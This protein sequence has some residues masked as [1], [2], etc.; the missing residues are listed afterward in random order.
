VQKNKKTVQQLGLG[1][2]IWRSVSSRSLFSNSD[3]ERRWVFA[4]SLILHT[5]PVRVPAKALRYTHTF[6]LGGTS[7]VLFMMLMST[8]LLMIFVY[9]P[10]PERAYQSILFMQEE[11]LFGRL[12][13]GV[14][15]WSANLLIAVAVLHML[16]VFLT[17]AFQAPRQSNWLIGLGLLFLILLSGFTGYLL[18]WDQISYWAITICTEM[19][20]Y[21][22]GIGQTLQRVILGGAEI[23][24]A[25]VINFYALHTII[26][27]LL[28]VVLMTWHFW[29]VRLAG[30]VVVPR[31]T[32]EESRSGTDYVPFI[33]NLL[34]RE[35]AVGLI[36]IAVVLV[37]AISFQA[38]LG[39]PANPG[40]SPNPAK[41]PWYFVGLQELLLHFH[42]LFAVFVIPL[43]VAT[44]I[45]RVA[46][47]RY[48]SD[49]SGNW[50]LSPKGRRM[51]AIAAATAVLITPLWIL[52]DEF[53]VGPGGWLPGTSPVISNGLL[54]CAAL[55]V[56][57]VA[58]YMLLKRHFSASKNETVQALFVLL[59]VGFAVFTVTGAWFR[60]AGMALMWPWQ[61]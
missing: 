39:E 49:L 43:V 50:F 37:V 36:V 15:Y 13:R 32:E 7:L 58:F 40:V 14:H 48:D 8:G 38:P 11:M 41:A 3:G 22:P 53:V 44:A 45:V 57:V 42:P 9:E 20:G 46:Y 24:S 19:L 47:V 21:M 29:R 5:R 59:A 51:S 10:S 26:V 34:L 55:A 31:D 4:N 28:L 2:R 17:G 23:G 33:P 30:G 60:G 6:G 27:P 52:V 54:P 35:V 25:T 56:G 16:R 18:P 12:I 1:A 61:T